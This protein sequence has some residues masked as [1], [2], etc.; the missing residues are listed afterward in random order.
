MPPGMIIGASVALRLWVKS[1]RPIRSPIA[2]PLIGTYGFAA[3]VLGLGRLSR[4]LFESGL[5]LQFLSMNL[6]IEPW[7]V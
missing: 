4:L 1:K 2:G 5:S 3:E 7:S 6:R